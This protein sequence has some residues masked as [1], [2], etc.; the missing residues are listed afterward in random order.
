M[1]SRFKLYIASHISTHT[2]INPLDS[3]SQQTYNHN[4]TKRN[5]YIINS[6]TISIK[7]K[8]PA[9]KSTPTAY[10]NSMERRNHSAQ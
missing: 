8:F 9:I 5:K 6:L 4:N 10:I 1:Y 7:Y 2:I 3:H